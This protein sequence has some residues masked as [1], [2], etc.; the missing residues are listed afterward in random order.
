MNGVPGG[1][2][3]HDNIL[4]LGST[5]EEYEANLEA[6]LQ[7]MEDRNLTARYNKCNFGK[8]SV[9]WFRWIFSIDGMS[10]QKIQSILYS[11]CIIAY[12]I[13]APIRA[14]A[15]KDATF[16]WSQ[17]CEDAYNQIIEAMTNETTLWPFDP[18]SKTKLVTDAGPAD[19]DASIFQELLDGT[20]VPID[21]ASRS[22]TACEMKY[23]QTEKESLA[24][25]WG[26]TIHRY[27]LLGIHF[28]LF[29]DHQPLIPI[30]SGHIK[31]NARVKRHCLK[32]QW[33]LE[34]MV[35]NVD[36]EHCIDKI[37]TDDL[38][39]AV[40]LHIIQVATKDPVSHKLIQAKS[41]AYIGND[42]ELKTYWRMLHE[43]TYTQGIILQG[44]K[45]V[46]P[47]TESTPGVGIHSP[48]RPP[49][50]RQVQA[51]PLIKGVVPKP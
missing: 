24:Q 5:A 36:Y 7:R 43:L 38:P 41:R 18:K 15:R 14:L 26:M 3:I 2:F 51:T 27:Y 13:T 25:A 50:H 44:D 28:Q 8:T 29:T 12:A 1:V 20:W 33:Q 48:R 6:C 46:I 32:V 45:L 11:Q 37:I 10:A 42:E 35:I 30:Y 40:T 21:H 17:E 16:K 19:I 4:V 22:L 49:R 47:E 31:G 39:A 23:S 9:S 34:E